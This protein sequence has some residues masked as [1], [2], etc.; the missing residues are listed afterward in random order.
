LDTSWGTD[1]I[2]SSGPIKINNKKEAFT[3]DLAIRLQNV[4]IEC[5]DAIYIINNRD[6]EDTFFY[7]A[8]PYYNA[9]MGHYDGYNIEDFELLLK[10]L[11]GIKGKFL[12]S[13]YPSEILSNY[14]T[15]HGW[16]QKSI[17]LVISVSGAKRAF[18][19]KRKIEVLTWNY[20]VYNTF[21]LNFYSN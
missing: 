12:L 15:K 18:K 21:K 13:S 7:C 3:E 16:H 8:P 1:N 17:T 2:K 19:T 10:T 9:D 11:A 6:R 14:T 4:Q 20:E 5:A